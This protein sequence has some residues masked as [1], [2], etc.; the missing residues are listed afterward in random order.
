MPGI[1]RFG[2]ALPLAL[3]AVVLAASLAACGGSSATLTHVPDGG[4]DV[5]GTQIP[6]ATATA[7]TANPT[8]TAP[9]TPTPEPTPSPSPTIGPCS[10]VDIS[11]D[12]TA[13]SGTYWQG[14]AGHRG[15]KFTLTNTGSVD[16]IVKAKAQPLLLNG[17]G[18]VLI[19]GAAAGT[20]ASTTVAA[21]STL[22]TEV[23]TGNL[24]HAPTISAPVRVAFVLPGIGTVISTTASP[25]D[26]GALPPC[27][28]DPAVKRGDISMTVW[29]P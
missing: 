28:G 27:L 21:G 11:I 3:G 5:N 29:A 2:R 16:C 12:I 19:T 24:C 25:T 10:P 13:D 14:P 26:T 8:P 23:Q 22:A 15:A 20:S 17:D 4:S 6:T 7:A 18:A 9:A 1:L